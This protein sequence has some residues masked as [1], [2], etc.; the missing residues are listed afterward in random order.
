MVKKYGYDFSEAFEDIFFKSNTIIKRMTIKEKNAFAVTLILLW[1]NGIS[2]VIL[3]FFGFR[4]IVLLQLIV[5]IFL[6]W[7]TQGLR[8]K[9]KSRL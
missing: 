9:A 6:S 4:V 8:R 7:I 3:L 2:M 5:Q 1:L